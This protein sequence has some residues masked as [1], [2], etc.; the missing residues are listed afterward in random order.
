MWTRRRP[1][2]G[3]NDFAIVINVAKGDRPKRPVPEDC[4][5]ETLPEDVWALVE[6]CWAQDPLARPHMA[7]VVKSIEELRRP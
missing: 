2:P 4:Q 7:D 5:G 6:K 3:L 1:F